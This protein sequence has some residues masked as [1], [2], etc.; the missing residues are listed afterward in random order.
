VIFGT[1]FLR[2]FLSVAVLLGS[3]VIVSDG[4]AQTGALNKDP[5]I[6]LKKYL[7]LDLKGA[8][9]NP[10]TWE[11]QKPYMAWKEE[12][13]WGHVVVITGYE[14]IEEI[15]QWDVKNNLDVV[16]PVEYKVV[17]SL[18]FEKAVFLP[19]PHVERIGFRLKAMNGL[20]RVVDPIVP[21]HV[22]QKRVINYVRQAMVEEKDPARLSALTALRDDVRRR[23]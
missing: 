19:E 4:Q 2:L 12:T 5:S 15:G 18:Y 6:L 7:D 1:P 10:L 16:I 23:Q 22:G 20:W 17:G 14:V 3:I 11:A 21:P 9:L 8:R 13:I